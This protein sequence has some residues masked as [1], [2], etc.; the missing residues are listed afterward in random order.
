[1]CVSGERLTAGRTG[2]FQPLGSLGSKNK[3]PATKHA[4]LGKLVCEEVNV[5]V[6]LQERTQSGHHRLLKLVIAQIIVTIKC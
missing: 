2:T 6:G 1:M 5:P 3:H 4:I